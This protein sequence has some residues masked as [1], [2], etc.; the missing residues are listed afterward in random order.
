MSKK[1]RLV[2]VQKKL[3]VREI[4]ELEPLADV[5]ELSKYKSYIVIVKK[6]SIIGI[7]PNRAM[8][9]AK[10]VAR[11]L[12]ATGIPCQLLVNVDNEVKF[13]EINK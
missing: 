7:D 13:L 5:Y 3:L 10:E 6:S 9:T 11:V 12:I 1:N 8:R 2:V 4:K